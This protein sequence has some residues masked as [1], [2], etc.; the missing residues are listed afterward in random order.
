MIEKD[1]ELCAFCGLC[2]EDDSN[3]E[4]IIND[5]PTGAL[6][7]IKTNDTSIKTINNKGRR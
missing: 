3:F 5:C 7:R 2:N 4:E 1:E 6:R